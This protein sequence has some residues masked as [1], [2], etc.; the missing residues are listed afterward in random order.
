MALLRG[1][2]GSTMHVLSSSLSTLLPP[3][4]AFPL[5]PPL[6]PSVPSLY[7]PPNVV[8]LAGLYYFF[9]LLF[10]TGRVLRRPREAIGMARSPFM[11]VNAFVLAL[12][13]LTYAQTPSSTVSTADPTTYRALFT[14]PASADVG[15]TLIPN[16]ADPEAVNAQDVCPGYIASNVLHTPSGLTADLTLAGPA[17]NVYGTDIERLSLTV[18]YQSADR[19]HIEILPTYIGV[20]NSS[21]FVL[22][23]V[24]VPKPTIDADANST[25]LN[26][27][28]NF[29][30]ANDPTFSFTVIRQST[31]DVLFTTE[32]SQLVYQN[33]F[34]EFVSALPENYNLYGLGEVIHGL[35]MGNNFTRTFWAADNGDPIDGNIYGTHPFYLDTRYYEINDTTGDLTYVANATDSS[36][37][38]TSYSHGVYVRNSHGQEVILSPKNIT[39]RAL[40]GAIDLTFFAGPTQV[41]VTKEYQLNAVG[42]PAMQQYFTFGFHQCRWGYHNWSDLQDVVDNFARFGIPLENIW[43]DIDYMKQYRD[44]ENDPN[45]FGYVEGAEFLSKL[46][47]NGQHYIPIVD[48]AVYI[49]NPENVT[50]AYPVFNRGNDTDSFMLNSDGSLYSEFGFFLCGCYTP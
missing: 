37:R 18:D 28:L 27:D 9:V 25:G 42:L 41:E 14:V 11:A 16:I 44:F 39:W 6:S 20:D 8:R 7:L 15:A 45:T 19:L 43:T 31:G 17:C 12:G 1:I 5:V 29:V 24:L 4:A 21:W 34:I 47:A 32:G 23:E 3:S 10:A 36:A 38:Y 35:R 26:S 48:S 22:P 2:H 13:T 33:Q 46:H 50:D 30:W 49:P 40:G